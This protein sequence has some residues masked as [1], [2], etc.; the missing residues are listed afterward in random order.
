MKSFLWGLT[1]IIILAGLGFGG[2][3]LFIKKSPEGGNCQSDT[4]CEQGLKCTNKTCSSG[5]VGST[6]AQKLDCKSGFC[7][8]N[9]C[10][11]GK[12]SNAC[13]T[14]KDCES[15][16]LCTKSVCTVKPDYSKYFNKIVI[17]KMKPG[18]PPG[19]N[20]PLIQTTNFV[21]STDAIEIDFMGVKSTTVG[22]YHIELIN[23]VTGERAFSTQD[24]MPTK[25][26]GRDTG[27][28]TDLSG[29]NAGEYDINVIYNNELVYSTIITVQ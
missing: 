29:V 4:K 11:E 26:E 3:Y 12:V 2:W 22:D 17:S 1:I 8:N 14:Y 18:S 23:S 28:G 10:T 27:T 7:V 9:I 21:A 19:S 15:G 20:N 16:L 25:F 5:N 13:A 24:R 6:C